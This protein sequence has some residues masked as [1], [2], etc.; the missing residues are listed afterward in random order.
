MDARL[1][2]PRRKLQVDEDEDGVERDIR[3]KG[4]NVQA[5]LCCGEI[6]PSIPILTTPE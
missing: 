6:H 5:T 2:D 3:M 4:N 1:I